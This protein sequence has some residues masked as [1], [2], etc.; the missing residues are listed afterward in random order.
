[1]VDISRSRELPSL[2]VWA[3]DLHGMG[4]ERMSD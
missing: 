4:M 3:V 2:S 1:M